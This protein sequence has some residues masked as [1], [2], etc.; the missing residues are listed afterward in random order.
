MLAEGQCPWTLRTGI[1]THTETVKQQRRFSWSAWKP[2]FVYSTCFVVKW[3]RLCSAQVFSRSPFSVRKSHSIINIS[4]FMFLDSL[5]LKRGESTLCA[6]RA[7][8]P[9]E[10][11]SCR[12]RQMKKGRMWGDTCGKWS[13]A[14]PWGRRPSTPTGR[15]LARTQALKRGKQFHLS[16]RVTGVVLGRHYSSDG[17]S[18]FQCSKCVHVLYFNWL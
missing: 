10:L 12:G 11:F 13:L 7:E 8:V 17:G 2:W 6:W 16:I 14:G 4:S 1:W 9:D 18:D 3:E 5:F 15:I